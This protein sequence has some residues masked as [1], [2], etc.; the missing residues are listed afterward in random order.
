MGFSEVL[1]SWL[2]PEEP[3]LILS[4]SFR[5]FMSLLVLFGR[6]TAHSWEMYLASWGD[7]VDKM[8]AILQI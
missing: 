8:T 5:Y 2:H 3:C 4:S 7:G 6:K 1:A